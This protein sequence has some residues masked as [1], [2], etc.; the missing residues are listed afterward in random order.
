MGLLDGIRVIDFSRFVSG[1]YCSMLLADLGADVI[2]VERPETGDN[3]RKWGKATAGPDNAYFMSVNRN[4]RSVALDLHAPEG[5]ARANRLIADA[6]VLLHNFRDSAAAR[7]GLSRQ[8]LAA[9][10][11]RLV[12]CQV[13]GFGKSVTTSRPALDFIV[14]A[15]SGLMATLGNPGEKPVKVP[16]PVSD[17]LTALH[18]CVGVLAALVGRTGTETGAMVE[19]S[20]FEA[21]MA[22]MTNLVSDYLVDGLLATPIGSRHPS[23]AP[24]EVHEAADG[25]FALGVSTESQWARFCGVIDRAD[26]CEDERFK[27]NPYRIAHRD[28]LDAQI[29]PILAAKTVDDWLAELSA[30]DVPCGRIRD[31]GEA[32][33]GPEAAALDLTG[34]V[35]HPIR[36]TVRMIRSPLIVNGSRPALG[37]PPPLLGQH[38]EEIVTELTGPQFAG[39]AT[40]GG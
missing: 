28:E 15:E 2:K 20:L 3:T 36:G 24:Y 25:Y 19:T 26:L 30:A 34:T 31:L 32:L 13:R 14:Q 16:F 7:F 11:P 17:V 12:V 4:K 22:S 9:L 39:E 10:N 5:R 33:D 8:E 21:T 35:A 1:P 18:A 27:S 29:N 37:L 6:D 38:T 23:S 40:K